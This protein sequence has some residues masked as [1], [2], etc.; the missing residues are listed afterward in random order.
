MEGESLCIK[1]V[2]PLGA[3]LASSERCPHDVVEVGYTWASGFRAPPERHPV[4]VGDGLVP[5]YVQANSVCGETRHD[6][7]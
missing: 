6:I 5:K 7:S 4:T 1:H 3:F 2:T